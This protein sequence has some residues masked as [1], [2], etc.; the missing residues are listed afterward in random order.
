MSDALLAILIVW[1]GLSV[2]VV[3]SEEGGVLNEEGQVYDGINIG[4][5]HM[6]GWTVL[7]D[8]SS[9]PDGQVKVVFDS[10]GVRIGERWIGQ[11]YFDEGELLV[12]KK[13][14]TSRLLKGKCELGI[15][16]AKIVFED[17]TVVHFGK[18]TC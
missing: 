6:P 7:A 8:S 10:G 9:T 3:L 5:L 4:Y 1:M 11:I 18:V 15:L 13:G 16:R 12:K 2:N 17:G 14:A